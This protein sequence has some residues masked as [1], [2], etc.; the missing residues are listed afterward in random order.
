MMKKTLGF[1]G[2]GNMAGALVKGL[3][4]SK[5]V[6]ANGIIVSDVKS[7]RLALLH[8]VS[9]KAVAWRAPLPPDMRALIDALQAARLPA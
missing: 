1:L 5:L 3:L 6:P 2:A 7:E 8:P 4:H 9:G